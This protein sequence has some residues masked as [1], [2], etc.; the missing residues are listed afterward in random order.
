MKETKTKVLGS[1]IVKEWKP[2]KLHKTTKE[3]MVFQLYVTSEFIFN[4]YGIEAL[5]KYYLFNQESYFNLKM[6]GILK[7]MEGILKKLPKGLKIKEGLKIMVDEFQFMESPKN[8]LIL[9]RTSKKATFEVTS[10][11]VRK[12]FNKLA[13]KSK[14]PDL[15]DACC[16]WCMESIP[17]AEKYGFKYAI[18]LTKKGCMNYL[19]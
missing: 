14:K 17:F 10:C 5:R 12:D 6:T 13:K 3:F 7:M 19:T 16:L 11:S 1:E 4:N 8:V 18:E 2:E 9:E 15:I